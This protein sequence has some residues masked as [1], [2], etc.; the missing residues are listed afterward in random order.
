MKISVMKEHFKEGLLVA[1]RAVSKSL[2]LPIL[3]NV[4]LTAGKNSL[5]FAATDL[6]IGIRYRILA[7]N[8]KEGQLVFPSRVLSP[9]VSLLPDSPMELQAQNGTMNIACGDYET[10]LNVLS[11]EEFP[12]IPNTKGEEQS[13]EVD[14]QALCTGIGQ[15]IGMVGQSQVRPEISGILFSFQDEAIKIVATDSFRLAEKTVSFPEAKAFKQNFILPQKTARE[16]LAIFGEK[17]GKLKISLSPAQ[18]IFEYADQKDLAR[19]FIQIVSRLVEGE[20]PQ[21][22]EIIPKKYQVRATV[23]RNEFMN[24]I[25]AASIFAGKT[26]EVRLMFFPEKNQIEISSQSSDVGTQSSSIAAEMK[27]ESGEAAF[28]WRFLLEGASVMKSKTIEIGLSGEESPTSFVPIEQ[29]GYL[30]IVMPIKN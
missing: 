22:Q 26:N 2:S 13:A 9:F 1:E 21:Y 18:V 20:Y 11:A 7:K 5:E 29:E 16:L 10:T 30:Y 6:E 14:I 24:R 19:P 25:R 28:N 17:E 15:V 23:D 3:G 8:D 27:G 12:L 4:L